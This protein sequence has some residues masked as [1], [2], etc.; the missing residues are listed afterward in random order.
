GDAIPLKGVDVVVLASGGEVI[1][2]SG[3]AN[4][5]AA[6]APPDMAPDTT[7]NARSLAFRFPFGRF[8]FLDC[9]GLTSNV[10]K[11]LVGPGDR[12]GAIDLFQVTHHGAANS[13]HPTLVRTI[14]PTVTVMNNGPRKGGTPEV[15]KLLKTIPSIQAAYQLHKNAATGPAENT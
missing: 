12:L 9:G 6:E 8:D 5:L 10:E 1:K 2:A 7:D 4:P 3:P 13:N 14:A 15:V 11:A